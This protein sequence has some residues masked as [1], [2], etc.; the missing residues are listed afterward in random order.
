MNVKSV[1]IPEDLVAAMEYVSK[2]EK[3][4]QAQALRKLARIGFESYV[5]RSYQDGRLTLREASKLLKLPLSG[6]LDLLASFGVRGNI[7]ASET[8]TSVRTMER[9]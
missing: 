8:L 7:R 5:A 1:R 3:I 6:T 2:A 9:S 4:E